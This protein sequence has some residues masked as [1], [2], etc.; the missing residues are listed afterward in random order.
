MVMDL[1]S[2][3]L[4]WEGYAAQDHEKGGVF[5]LHTSICRSRGRRLPAVGTPASLYLLILQTPRF[6]L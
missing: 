1:P 6:I 4:P 2:P 5:E 3:G